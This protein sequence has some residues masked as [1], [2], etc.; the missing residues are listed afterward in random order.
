MGI[1]SDLLNIT[2]IFR[3]FKFQSINFNNRLETFTHTRQ[4]ISLAKAAV[5][6]RSEPSK[7]FEK[8]FEFEKKSIEIGLWR[9]YFFPRSRYIRVEYINNMAGFLCA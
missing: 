7:H 9:S 2:P 6:G 1:D 3:L 4:Y 5:W 8:E